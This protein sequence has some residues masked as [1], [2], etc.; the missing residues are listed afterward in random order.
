MKKFSLLAILAMAALYAL[1]ASAQVSYDIISWGGALSGTWNSQNINVGA[2]SPFVTG[3][4]PL[5]NVDWSGAPSN[6]TVFAFQ[7]TG[8]GNTPN[9]QNI[10]IPSAP[11][12]GTT[13]SIGGGLLTIG[14][15]TS[16]NTTVT[17]A[18]TSMTAVASPVTYPG[19]GSDWKAYVSAANTVTVKVCAIVALTPTASNYNVR[20]LQ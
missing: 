16:G 17:G 1:P 10:T 19:D 4:L 3:N 6:G 12:S 7:S 15:C 2:G 13:G 9:I 18:T 20:V 8:A 5:S 14:A 11:L